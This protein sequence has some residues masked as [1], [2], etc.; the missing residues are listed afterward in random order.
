MKSKIL[1]L[2]ASLKFNN[3]RKLQKDCIHSKNFVCML[4][5]KKKKKT[6]QIGKI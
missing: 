2:Q 1:F 3:Q 5:E 4:K 6:L